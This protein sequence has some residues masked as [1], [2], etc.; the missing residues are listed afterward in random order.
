MA[1]D[2]RTPSS[3]GE[4]D[5]RGAKLKFRLPPSGFS[6][7]ATATASRRV[8]L[9]EPFSPTRKVTFGWNG[10]VVSPRTAG[11][12]YGKRLGSGMSS[13]SNSKCLR[14]GPGVLVRFRA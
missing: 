5:G 1:F 9:P 13:R 6:P 3:G 12:L 14:Y 8:D 7:Q 10:R 11:R 2:R 4:C